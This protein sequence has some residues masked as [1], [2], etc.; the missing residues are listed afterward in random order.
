M[1]NHL[2]AQI[3]LVFW[4]LIVFIVF[5]C[6]YIFL[7]NVSIDKLEN[8]ITI[9]ECT[10]FKIDSTKISGIVIFSKPIIIKGDTIDESY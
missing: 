4:G 1:I 3:K 8:R 2:K 9:L 10:V 7:I 5:A 6:I